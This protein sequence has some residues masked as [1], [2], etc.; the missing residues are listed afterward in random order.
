MERTAAAEEL[1]GAVVV[2]AVVEVESDGCDGRQ[3]GEVV[4]ERARDEADAG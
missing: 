3:S 4:E 1:E 2:V